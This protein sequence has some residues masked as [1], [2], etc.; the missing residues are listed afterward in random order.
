MRLVIPALMMTLGMICGCNP[1]APTEVSSSGEL[2][3]NFGPDL[4][5]EYANKI[6]DLLDAFD[7]A[8]K[9]AEHMD[10]KMMDQYI[11]TKELP[12]PLLDRLNQ[13][14][15]REMKILQDIDAMHPPQEYLVFHEQ[16]QKNLQQR[17]D[18]LSGLILAIEKN[19]KV[20]IQKVLDEAL[21]NGKQMRI[22]MDKILGGKTAEQYL[23]LK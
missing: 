9:N 8:A 3:P 21:K 22:E 23:G 20:E 11:A 14:V 19:D 15:A 5:I 10:E 6:L 1:K 18:N 4:K 12:K 16:V 13:G 17:I 2:K 7:R